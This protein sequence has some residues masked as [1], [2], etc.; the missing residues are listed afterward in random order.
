M[1]PYAN[2]FPNQTK[3]SSTGKRARA[4]D[5]HLPKHAKKPK[6]GN[7]QSVSSRDETKG[8]GPET[9]IDT[10][11]DPDVDTNPAVEI[12]EKGEPFEGNHA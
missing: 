2:L 1:M 6:L 8:E 4:D 3:C 7:R 5:R 9:L 12:E 10:L 11:S